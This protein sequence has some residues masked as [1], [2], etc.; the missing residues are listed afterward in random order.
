MS[1]NN[2][3]DDKNIYRRQ[4][5]QMSEEAKKTITLKSEM[6]LNCSNDFELGRM[7][8]MLLYEKIDTCN[9]HIKHINSL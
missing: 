6:I 4:M 2:V 7:V 5:I 8:R 1:Q 3:N 9:E